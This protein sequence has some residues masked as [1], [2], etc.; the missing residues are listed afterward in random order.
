[1]NYVLSK[2]QLDR[3]M[4]PYWDEKFQNSKLEIIKAHHEDWFGFVDPPTGE[5]ILGRPAD[6]SDD[7]WYS[8]GGY[9]IGGSE[10]FGLSDVEF[11]KALLRYI[12]KSYNLNIRK[13]Y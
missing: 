1:M 4:K 12:N 7:K 9:F 10:L 11:R 5:I 13:I 2:E 8:W 6:A 3:V